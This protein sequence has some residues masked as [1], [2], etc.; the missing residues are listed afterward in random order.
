MPD[1]Y[2]V[3]GLKHNFL[4]IGQL[5]QKAYRVYMEDNHC[6]IKEIRPRNQ[7]IAKVPMTSNCLFPLRITPENSIATFKEQ[8]KEVVVHHDKKEND[9]VENLAAFQTDVQDDSWLWH[10]I[11]GHLNFGGLKLLC[12]K[13]MVKGLSLIEKTK[14]VK[15]AFLESNINK[16]F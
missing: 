5:I 12:M 1:V 13:N 15:D 11:F 3:E 4:S 2:H 6:V 7:L 14:F 8:S 16:L 10:F 9:N